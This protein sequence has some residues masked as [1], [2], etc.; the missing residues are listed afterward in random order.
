MICK[1]ALDIVLSESETMIIE[2]ADT[3]DGPGNSVIN[4]ALDEFFKEEEIPT[5]LALMIRANI[6]GFIL[7]DMAIMI[8]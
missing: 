2:W 8:W 1:E 4:D 5:N 6:R 3:K 7:N